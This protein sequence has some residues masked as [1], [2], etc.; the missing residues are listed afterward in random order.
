LALDRVTGQLSGG[1]R[2]RLALATTLVVHPAVLLLDEPTNHLDALGMAF[3][4]DQLVAWRGPVLFASHDRWFI[5]QVATKV[6][7]LDPAMVPH[8][9]SQARA[10]ATLTAYLGNYS[11]FRQARAAARLAW[12]QRYAR[13]QAELKEL[14]GQTTVGWGQVFHSR[15]P[16]TEAHGSKK[17]YAD[18]AANTLARRGR[19][20]QLKVEKLERDQVAR[21][22]RQLR[23]AGL[24]AG[25][26]RPVDQVIMDLQAVAVP[27]RLAKVSLALRAQDRVLVLGDNAA[28]KSTL[29]AVMAGRLAP[30]Q[31]Q[32]LLVGKL[33]IGM[34][35]QDTHWDQ[36]TQT[37]LEAFRELLAQTGQAPSPG[38]GASAGATVVDRPRGSARGVARPAGRVSGSAGRR[39]PDQCGS[40]PLDSRGNQAVMRQTP[41]GLVAPQDLNRPVGQLSVGQQRRL[42]L[43]ALLTDPPDVLLL[44]EPT[45]HI[46]LT[47]SEELEA[48]LMDFPGAV[49]VA[50]H[51]Q[52]LRQHWPGRV[53]ELTPIS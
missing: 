25:R 48:A 16:R 3:L 13:E 45:N 2:S 38:A 31:G 12:E 8:S 46:S 37:A 30:A 20:A 44:D 18:R 39:S 17:F 40:W 4:V 53:M 22:P 33:R 24:A 15:Q 11:D 34:L 14:R 32:R 6:L 21:P 43:A 5:D 28:G 49:V 19:A 51:D 23:F 47:L 52:Y 26:A 9:V 27:G 35:E 42:Q 36:P 10:G 50:S 1:Q 29:L 41:G 7:D